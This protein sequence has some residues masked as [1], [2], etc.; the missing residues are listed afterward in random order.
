MKFRAKKKPAKKPAKPA[1]NLLNLSS[2][3]AKNLISSKF[4][5]EFC[6]KTFTRNYGH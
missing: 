4:K 5:C 2:E 6:E 3:P 1:E